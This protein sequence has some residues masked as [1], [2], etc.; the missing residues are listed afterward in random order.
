MTSD[1]HLNA[2]EVA[3]L[4]SYIEDCDAIVIGGQSIALWAE[5]F[6]SRN[7]ALAAIGAVTSKDID[8][9]ADERAAAK[10]ADRLVNSVLKVPDAYAATP[11]AAV[12]VGNLNDRRIQI[13]FMATVLGVDEH[14]ILDRFVTISGYFPN[15]DRVIDIALLHPLDCVKSRLANINTLHR[16]DDHS[17]TQTKA[18]MLIL[19][20]FLQEMVDQDQAKEVYR[21]AH[22]YAFA[23]KELYFDQTAYKVFGDQADP[24]DVLR[25]LTGCD[26]LDARWRD[27]TLTS[28]I[29]RTEKKQAV[30]DKRMEAS[31]ARAAQ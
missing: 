14:D 23:L 30:A 17:L 15:I 27:A 11:N 31:A 4:L 2:A 28:L 18:S 22:E 12:V 6:A 9:F 5:Y 19:D 8:F 13:D 21:I 26:K 20:A 1:N 3:Q 29:S 24:I 10:F 25:K 7:D 16:T